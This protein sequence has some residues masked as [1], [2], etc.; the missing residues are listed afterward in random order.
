MANPDVSC[1]IPNID[2][3][4]VLYQIEHIPSVV[5]CS[6]TSLMFLCLYDEGYVVGQILYDSYI[7]GFSG[8]ETPKKLEILVRC[9]QWFRIPEAYQRA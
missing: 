4:S 6:Y 7:S 5:S 2:T 9:N 1:D 3:G 8:I